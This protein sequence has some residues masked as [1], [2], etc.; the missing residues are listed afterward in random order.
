MRFH[1]LIRHRSLVGLTALAAA[2]VFSSTALPVRAS[3]I[4][5]SIPEAMEREYTGT[6]LTVGKSFSSTSAYTKHRI[7]YESGGLTISGIMIKPRGSGPFPVV[8]LGHGYIDPDSYWSG[9]GFRREQDWLGKNGYVALHVDYRN[10]AKSD[11]DPNNDLSM[12]LGYAEDV[13]GA[14]LAVKDSNYSYLDKNKVALLGRSMGGGVAF[15]ALVIQPGVFDAAIVY[16]AT[17]TLAADNFNKW[18]RNDYPIG[19]QIL[20]KYGT[21]KENPEVWRDMSSRYFFSQITEP[22]LMIHGTKDESCNISWARATHR[23]LQRS[24]VDVTYVEYPGAPHYMYG[25]WNDS[26]KRVGKFLQKNLA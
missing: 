1:R 14:A 15:Q 8:V 17:S 19:K 18:Q 4:G 26:I 20:K 9:Q 7:T 2:L 21:P 22:V 16:A 13:I 24:G 10:H 12:P 6:D 5:N 3:T 25:E 11:K 23:A